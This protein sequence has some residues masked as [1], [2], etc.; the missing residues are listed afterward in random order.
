MI[1]GIVLFTFYRKGFTGYCIPIRQKIRNQK[2]IKLV[3]LATTAKISKGLLSQ[4]ENNRT[5]PS[6]PVLIQIISALEVDF[7]DFFREIENQTFSQA[8]FI[9]KEDYQKIQ[10]EEAV[11]FEYSSI[12]T[13]NIGNVSFQF[14][15]LELMPHAK[16]QKVTTNGYTYIYM[17]AGEVEYLLDKIPYLLKEGDSLF[18]NGNIPHVP[19][20]ASDSAA[21]MFVLNILTAE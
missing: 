9:R 14:N 1:G 15:I 2:K 6:L 7:S 16:R 12:L 11:G 10:K 20:N 4:I 3:Q 5:I 8:V 17:L 19:Y 21:R 13:E 18:F